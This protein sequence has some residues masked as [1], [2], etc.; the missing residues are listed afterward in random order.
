MWG[1]DDMVGREGA[2][3]PALGNEQREPGE[4]KAPVWQSEDFLTLVRTETTIR[5]DC[6]Q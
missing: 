6:P 1:E 5:G 2:R 3:N 4:C